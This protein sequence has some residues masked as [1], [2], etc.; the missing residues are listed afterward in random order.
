M[1]RPAQLGM[2]LY[3]LWYID[4]TDCFIWA[5]ECLFEASTH[6][7]NVGKD[8]DKWKMVLHKCVC[9]MHDIVKKE[10]VIISIDKI[11]LNITFKL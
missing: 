11:Y 3:S 9:I 6:F 7:S 4:Q 1:G 5:E 8:A 10:T 2:L